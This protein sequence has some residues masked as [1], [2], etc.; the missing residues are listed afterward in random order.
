M[1]SE[2]KY[3]MFRLL[4]GIVEADRI[5]NTTNT[6]VVLSDNVMVYIETDPV[7]KIQIRIRNT[8]SRC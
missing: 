6:G 2:K 8:A 4:W 3:V 7:K 5:Q 1:Y